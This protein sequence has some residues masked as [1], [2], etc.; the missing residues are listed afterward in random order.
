[1]TIANNIVLFKLFAHSTHITQPL[2]VKVFQP[3]KAAHDNTVEKAIRNKDVKF[4]RFSFLTILKKIR[5]FVFIKK[6][7]RNVWRRCKLN[8][9]NPNIILNSIKTE[10]IKNAV[11]ATTRSAISRFDSTKCLKRTFRNFDFY[12][13]NIFVLKKHYVTHRNWNVDFHQMNRFIKNIETIINILQL[14]TR[15]LKTTQKNI[16][17]RTERN[18]ISNYKVKTNDIISVN[19]CKKQ[20]SKRVEKKT[21]KIKNRVKRKTVKVEKKKLKQ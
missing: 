1:M 16:A 19:Q 3:Y 2:D 15:D 6:T 5:T 10:I 4:N 11:I 8:F 17:Q 13:R 14:T 9:L 20:Y 7:I 21:I 18:V 12:K